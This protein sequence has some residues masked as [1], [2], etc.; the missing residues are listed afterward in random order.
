MLG[1]KI[2]RK[3]IEKNM[4]LKE[5]AEKIELTASFLSQVEREL[6]EPSITSLRKIAEALDVPIFYF[7]LDDEDHSPVVRKSQ[8]KVLRFPQSHLTYELLSPDLNRQM[9]VLIARLDPG[10]SSGD[11]ASSHPGE[12]CILVLEGKME[13]KVGEETYYLEEGD[14]IYYFAS[15][16]HSLRNCGDGQLVFLSAITPPQF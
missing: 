4:S 15:I 16:P 13:I 7:L 8:R 12:E 2:R 14:S 3:R 5:L 6:A 10:A 11:E 1:E 9:E